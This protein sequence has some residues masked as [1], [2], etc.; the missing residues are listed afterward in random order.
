MVENWNSANGGVFYGK[1]SQ[2]EC[3]LALNPAGRVVEEKVG[4][5]GRSRP[6]LDG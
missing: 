4:R 2:Q 3:L 6:G 5:P 1:D